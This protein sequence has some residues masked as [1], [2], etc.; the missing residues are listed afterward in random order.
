[1]TANVALRTARLGAGLSLEQLA[2]RIQQNGHRYGHPNG[3][4][5]ATVHR[6][7]EGAQP[8]PHYVFLLEA[9]LGQPA[10]DLGIA[11]ENYG[12]DRQQML[13]DANLDVLM[14]VPD[15]TSGVVYG[16]LSGVWLSRYV[17]PSSSRNAEFVGQHYVLILQRGQGLMVRSLPEQESTLSLDLSVN[18]NMARGTWTEITS[19]GGY[20]QGAVYDGAIQMEIGPAQDRMKGMWVGFGRNPGEMN[21]GEWMFT[22]VD[23]KYDRAT[24]QK[25]DIEPPEKA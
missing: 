22:R 8:Q 24:R 3:C 14:P 12:M 11:Y 19:K 10:A 16:P 25:W 13:E 1:M 23:E 20:Y 18:G 6:W 5:R 7:E 4:N 2:L 21:T 15:E 9:T 17:Y